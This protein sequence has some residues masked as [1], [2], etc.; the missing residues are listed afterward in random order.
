MNSFHGR[1]VLIEW[2]VQLSDFSDRFLKSLLIQ[3]GWYLMLRREG[4]VNV[5]LVREFYA[6]SRMSEAPE[7]SIQSKVRGH[8]VSITAD[9]V[10]ELLTVSRVLKPD[11]KLFENRSLV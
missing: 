3:R 11:F 10:C 8:A 7:I 5:N 9:D 6:Y 1:Q 2:R 4:S